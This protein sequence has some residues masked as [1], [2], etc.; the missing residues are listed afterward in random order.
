MLSPVFSNRQPSSAE[1]KPSALGL[2]ES[3][4]GDG[5]VVV[6]ERDFAVF[7]QVVFELLA[8]FREGAAD[9]AGPAVLD[10]EFLPGELSCAL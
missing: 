2:S 7:A 8:E 3:S 5:R 1:V 6:P 4:S 9:A 10:A